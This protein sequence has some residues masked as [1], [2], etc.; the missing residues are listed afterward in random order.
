MSDGKKTMLAVLTYVTVLMIII[1]AGAANTSTKTAPPP[2]PKAGP[3]AQAE[4]SP[5]DRS[6]GRPD[7]GGDTAGQSANP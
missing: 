4:I 2:I 1:C 5:T 3:L 6:S 7:A